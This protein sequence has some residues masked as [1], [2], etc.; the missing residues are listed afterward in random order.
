MTQTQS[1]EVD[2]K[3]S[4][5]PPRLEPKFRRAESLGRIQRS[6]APV[7][8]GHVTHVKKNGGPPNG[9]QLLGGFLLAAI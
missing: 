2:L 6:V 5:T 9:P 8:Y 3:S 1:S 4:Q 7:P